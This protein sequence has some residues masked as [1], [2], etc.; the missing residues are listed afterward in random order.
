MW[1]ECLGKKKVLIALRTGMKDQLFGRKILM[2]MMGLAGLSALHPMFI[3][4]C[5][6]SLYNSHPRKKKKKDADDTKNVQLIIF[7]RLTLSRWVIY[8]CSF[9]FTD[10]CR[11]IFTGLRSIII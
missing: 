8:H 9:D 1:N 6:H 4:N 10:Y 7:A 3:Y 11:V 5:Q 2:F